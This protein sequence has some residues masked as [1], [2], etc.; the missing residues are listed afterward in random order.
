LTTTS[1]P[2]ICE[3]PNTICPFV[4]LTMLPAV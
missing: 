2:R 1:A 3:M 4:H